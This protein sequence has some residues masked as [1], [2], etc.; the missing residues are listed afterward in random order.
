MP[1]NLRLPGSSDFSD[2]AYWAV[3]GT[4]TALA[5]NQ[6]LIVNRGADSF[7]SGLDQSAKDFKSVTF[8]RTYTGASIG[9]AGSPLKFDCD[10]SGSGVV[11]VLCPSQLVH[12][13]GGT[14]AV[15]ASTVIAP[16]NAM[17]RVRISSV[18]Q[19]SL[20]IE[21]GQVEIADSVTMPASNAV[22]IFGGKHSIA[23]HAGGS[24]TPTIFVYSGTVV[25][26]R[27]FTAL[28]IFGDATVYLDLAEGET[29]GDVYLRGH[30]QAAR[31]IHVSGNLG[32]L[33]GECGVYDK[34]RLT[35]AATCS[36]THQYAGC[37]EIASPTRTADVNHG[38]TTVFGSGWKRAS[39]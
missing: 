16:G 6:D 33:Y 28:Y 39:A 9:A 20:L 30:P 26:Q 23:K 11:R 27:D 2:S 32:T 15:H 4:P 13:A 22:R 34:S 31:L 1:T 3:S 25:L 7:T 24:N 29:G 10:Q 12:L 19:T 18:T 38:T 36:A 21:G 35:R 37:T 5:S 17:T 14:T 8:E